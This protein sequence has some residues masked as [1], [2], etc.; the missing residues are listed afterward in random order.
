VEVTAEDRVAAETTGPATVGDGV[1]VTAEDRVACA[2][3]GIRGLLRDGVEVTAEDRVA[4]ETTGPATVG[5]GVG[6]TADDRVVAGIAVGGVVAVE[7]AA[8]MGVELSA[9]V[10]KTA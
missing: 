1:G 3:A 7:A 4:A 9:W 10:P 2:R 6:V 8:E 5:D